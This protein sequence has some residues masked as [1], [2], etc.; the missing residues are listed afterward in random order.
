MPDFSVTPKR[1]ITK[2]W[3][4]LIN[5]KRQMLD[6][7]DRKYDITLSLDTSAA[8]PSAFP[9]EFDERVLGRP[10]AAMTDDYALGAKLSEATRQF[11][12]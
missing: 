4:A 8:S 9:N 1:E 3:A 7:E 12:S 6:M 2:A 11:L 5:T 10:V